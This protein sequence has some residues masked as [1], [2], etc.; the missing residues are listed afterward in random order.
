MELYYSVVKVLT[1]GVTTAYVY[2]P[3]V[4][5]YLGELGCILGSTGFETVMNPERKKA[6]VVRVFYV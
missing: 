4:S 5:Y 3:L 1:R 2:L 6:T